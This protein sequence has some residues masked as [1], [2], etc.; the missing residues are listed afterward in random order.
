[1]AVGR[2]RRGTEEVS[3]LQNADSQ[4]GG[5]RRGWNTPKKDLGLLHVRLSLKGNNS[6]LPSQGVKSGS[7]P[8]PSLIL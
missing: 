1:M 7:Q 3:K 5:K 4:Q 8:S 2:P 6:Q